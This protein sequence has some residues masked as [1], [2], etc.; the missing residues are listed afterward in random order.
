VAPLCKEIRAVAPGA[1]LEIGGVKIR[2][3]PSSNM[4]KPFHP[5]SGGRL[6]FVVTMDGVTVYHAGDTDAIPEMGKVRCDVA[7]LPV[8]GTYVMTADEAASAARAIRPMAVV[9]MHYGDIVGGAADAKKLQALLKGKINVEVLK[10]E[11]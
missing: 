4:G 2:T 5:K 11:E 8:S 10:K 7:L 6:G 9:P 1:E 3:V